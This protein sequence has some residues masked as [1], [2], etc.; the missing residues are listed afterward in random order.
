MGAAPH[1][2]RRGRKFDQV[3]EGARAIFLRDGFERASVDDIAREAG[4]SKATL[5][6]YFPD[7]RLLFME[8][9][10]SEC[11]R[12]AD[13]AEVLI[14]DTA[15]VAEVLTK[16]AERFVAFLMSDFGARMFR[17]AVAESENGK[18]FGEEFTSAK[19]ATD[20]QHIAGSGPYTVQSMN[21][22]QGVVLIKKPNWWGENAS[23][24]N[25]MLLAYPKQLVYKIVKDEGATESLLR[26]QDLDLVTDV[27]PTAFK[28]MQQDT[29]LARLYEF[30]TGW[31][32]RYGRLLL[33]LRHPDSNLLGDVRVRRA[34]AYTLDYDYLLNTV[35]QGFAKPIVGPIH[36][37]KSYY[38]KDISPYTYNPAE[39]KR[40]LNEAGWADTDRDGILDKMMNGRR[41]PLS[42]KLL[43]PGGIALSEMIA[44]NIKD[45]AR[46]LQIDI[47][48]DPQ[49]I[50]T[51]IK[52]IGEGNFQLANTAAVNQ[53]GL[54]ELT[55]PFHSTSA[56]NRGRYKNVQLDS[57]IDAIRT[58]EN[59][60]IRSELYVK[61][62]HII[63]EDVPVIFLY[64]AER[65]YI[66]S[67]KYNY[68]LTAEG[69]GFFEQMFSRKAKAQ[70]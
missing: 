34:L 22:D 28:A 58:T 32:P 15:P 5:Y 11:R 10:K 8:I 68:V 43:T 67:K 39:A 64:A 7:K 24:S 53:I 18:A 47:V 56:M 36:P 50:S 33:N 55:Q 37:S 19:F 21:G 4:V 70:K 38:A 6:S 48:L 65:R 69:L 20:L 27:S 17:V 26:T 35:Q 62:Q 14:H 52:N 44:Q 45:K 60:K 29:Q 66:I 30:R 61:A 12:Q 31:V 13:E 51:I 23:A 2:I 40:L 16:A 59:E 1:T 3:I 54:D 25:P 63:Y 49:D 9:A 57:I 46:Q 42:L 41:V